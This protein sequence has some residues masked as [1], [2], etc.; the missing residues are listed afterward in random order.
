MLVPK[1]GSHGLVKR[2]KE[3]RL[4]VVDRG[5]KINDTPPQER[6]IKAHRLIF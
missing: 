6:P 1:I 4:T 5:T 2:I 3:Y